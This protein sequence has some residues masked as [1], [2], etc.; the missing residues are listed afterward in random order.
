MPGDVRLSETEGTRIGGAHI[1]SAVAERGQRSHRTTELRLKRARLGL[2]EPFGRALQRREPD[3]NLVPERD[4]QGLLKMGSPR[5]RRIAMQAGEIGK[6]SHDLDELG[7]DQR[8]RFAQL[9]H[10][11][12]IHDVLGGRPPMHVAAG[13]AELLR[14]LA[15]QADD[16]IADVLGVALQLPAIERDH[17]RLL[18]DRLGRLARNDAGFALG[19]GERHFSLHIGFELAS[20]ENT[21][22]MAGVENTSR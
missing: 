16:G 5:H 3:R 20:S 18:R 15:Y 7:F 1:Q 2:F 6:G 22:R 19:H 12:C 21:A 13:F 9:Q 4:R 14:E 17:W 11:R 10:R 8:Y